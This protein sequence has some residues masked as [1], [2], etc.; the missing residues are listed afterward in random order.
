MESLMKKMHLQKPLAMALAAILIPS[1][2]L[3][4]A[5]QPGLK[6]GY[7]N[8]YWETNNYP[9]VT[10]QQLGPH[11]GA[12]TAEPPWAEN[13][14][15][16]Y[17]GKIYLDG[18]TYY[19]AENI[20]NFAMM[21]I[22]GAVLIDDL[23]YAVPTSSGA[24]SLPAGWHDIEIRFGNGGG[25]GGPTATLGWTTTKGFGYKTGGLDSTNGVDYVYPEDD[26]SMTLF[27]WDDGYDGVVN[28]PA[29]DITAASAV[30]NGRLLTTNLFNA[31]SVFWGPT[32]GGTNAL[33]WTNR[34][35]FAFPA[36][37]GQF[38]TNVTLAAG[39]TLTFYRYY[40]S[41]DTLTAW[42]DSTESVLSGEL[43]IQAVDD[44]ASEMTGDTGVFRVSRPATATNGALTVFYTL[45]G[46]AVNGVDY[47]SLNG[48]VVIPEGETSADLMI[49]AI[50]D[51]D[52][53][54]GDES[55]SLTLTA[56]S[57]IIGTPSVDSLTLHDSGSLDQ[58]EHS[59]PIVFAGYKG[60]E[61]LAGFPAL[62][63]LGTNINGFS[64]SGM[65]SGEHDDLRFIDGTMTQLLNYEIESWNTDGTSCIWV[66]V[67]ALTNSAVIWMSWGRAGMTAPEYNTNGATWSNGYLSVWHFAEIASTNVI[68]SAGNYN[69]VAQGGLDLTASGLIGSGGRF[70]G[71][72]D[73]VLIGTMPK[74]AGLHNL[75]VSGWMNLDT[76]GTS[77]TDDSMLFS[78]AGGENMLIWYNYSQFTSNDKVYSFNIGNTS[79][80][81][82]RANTASGV[83]KAQTW[84]Y[85][86]G[87]LNNSFRQLYVDGILR[88]ACTGDMS[89]VGSSSTVNLGK[90]GGSSYN[91]DGGMDEVRVSTVSRSAD[92]IQAEYL[93]MGSNSVF[94]VVPGTG[95]SLFVD[96]DPLQSG[97]PQPSYGTT[98]LTGGEIFSCT[99]PAIVDAGDGMG[100]AC[101]GYAI[102]S[103]LVELVASGSGNSCIYT[104]SGGADRLV[105]QWKTKYYVAFTNSGP[106]SVS[107]PAGWYDL[108]E[109]VG[110]T[111]TGTGGELFVHWEDPLGLLLTP[112]VYASTYLTVTQPATLTAVFIPP[113]DSSGWS[114]R[115][116]ITFS[117]YDRPET[118]TNFP[119]MVKL[120][121]NLANYFHYVDMASPADAGDLRFTAGDG[122]TELV[123]DIEKWDTNGTST[124]WVRLPELSS[125]NNQ[126]YAYWGNP[127]EIDPPVYFGT[128][129]TWANDFA[130]VY[131]LAEAAGPVKDSSPF[132]N[133]LI[134]YNNIQQGTNGI[135]GPAAGW[136]EG[137][138]NDYLARNSTDSL[139]GMGQL[140]LQAWFY[141]TQNDTLP[142]GLI[143]KRNG[144]S[145]KDYYFFKYQN[146]NIWWYIGS[147]GGEFANTLTAADQWYFT[148]A[149]Y[150]KNLANDRMKVYLDGE[151]RSVLNSASGDVPIN[152]TT[153]CLGILDEGYT[154]G[155][156]PCCWE[157]RLDEVRISRAARSADWIWAEYENVKN[158]DTFQSYSM[159]F[160]GLI[161][162]VR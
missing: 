68:D 30:L 27:R 119:V 120:T 1:L 8:S 22:D 115:L 109:Q 36:A 128:G 85:V 76:L 149:T 114:G 69:G 159:Y 91:H 121:E 153:L 129:I 81:T 19:F 78:T 87:V 144:G 51:N 126:I 46:T 25:A 33:A 18:G 98:N 162:I 110:C 64:Y 127:S 156:G 40:M 16:V 99:A 150:D 45:G 101:T 137:A 3:F 86:G 125:S 49:E 67:P 28:D 142:R 37:Q 20:N 5:W 43:S 118:L 140:T 104:N 52:M 112:T 55:V 50:E 63:L 54:E 158:H 4:A 84:Q 105:W 32:D 154:S 134:A 35:D 88:N 160:S 9:T 102:Y 122:V 80:G 107:T 89:T 92:W 108:G 147:S 53:T 2:A 132:G 41:N 71:T 6:A 15:W 44:V 10:E 58:W 74:L 75:T 14:T 62:V 93:N 72:D 56:G 90:W 143:S 65:L 21:A 17:T 47:T 73:A 139:H 161:I 61:T 38:S 146:R 59:V 82:N 123:Y 117:G 103:N 155:G 24:V 26:G 60:T 136:Q 151:L 130:A 152:N 39:D 96:G 23:D 116:A 42:A 135:S 70:D 13:R 29:S 106:G 111:A 83:A 131:H 113:F 94:Q 31:V 133:G 145:G 66:Q 97:A 124:I 57:Y 79:V 77:N 141:D 48:S 12:T 34:I 148:S 11:T 157:G 7:L 95:P 138:A 100:Y